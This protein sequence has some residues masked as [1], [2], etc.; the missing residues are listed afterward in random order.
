MIG[1]LALEDVDLSLL[2]PCQRGV[3]L[4]GHAIFGRQVALRDIQCE[5]LTMEPIG[6]PTSAG[7]HLGRIGAWRHADEDTFLRSP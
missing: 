1:I 2:R 3:S 5:Q 6:V 4:E 7:E